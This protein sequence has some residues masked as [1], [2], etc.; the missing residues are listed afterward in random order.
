[1][2]T[3]AEINLIA[4]ENRCA[5]SGLMLIAKAMV[6]GEETEAWQWILANIKWFNNRGHE[7]DMIELVRLAKGVGLVR[8]NKGKV[9]YE[10]N[11][12]SDGELHGFYTSTYLSTEE[13]TYKNGLKDGPCKQILMSGDISCIG[14]Y[15]DD[16]KD[17]EWIR[18]YS[19]PNDIYSI[20]NYKEGKEHG[21]F[22]EF[23]R[24]GQI[25]LHDECDNGKYLGDKH[26][27]W[28]S[29]GIQMDHTFINN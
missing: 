24:G 18:Y 8:D 29:D 21:V 14:Q 15:K 10:A 5:Y 11:Y 1:M 16:K 12:N 13:Y 27:A 26:K 3:L 23:H 7:I 19:Y 20:E 25:R 22:Q 9:Y 2:K 6:S 4:I 28:Y 17:G